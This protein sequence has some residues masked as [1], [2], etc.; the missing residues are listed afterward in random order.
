MV[1]REPWGAGATLSL[2]SQ[3]WKRGKG[4]GQEVR[5][6]ATGRQRPEWTSQPT[7]TEKFQSKFEIFFFFSNDFLNLEDNYFI[8]S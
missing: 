8:M 1:F 4:C 5:Q 7:F 2:Q 6:G 3:C